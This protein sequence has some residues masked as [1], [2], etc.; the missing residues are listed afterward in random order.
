VRFTSAVEGKEGIRLTVSYERDATHGWVPSGWESV[1]VNPESGALVESSSCKVTKYTVNEPIPQDEFDIVF[2]PGTIVHDDAAAQTYLVR[3]R[4]VKRVIT[5]GER[6]ATYEEILATESGMAGR[7]GRSIT[8]WV[9]CAIALPIA[10]LIALFGIRLI[11]R[12]RS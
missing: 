9:L 6:G 10:L 12:A 11:R 2:P 5:P 3:D 8:P 1:W 7:V 4:N